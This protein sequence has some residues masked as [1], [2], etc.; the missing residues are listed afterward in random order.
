M[1]PMLPLNSHDLVETS[2]THLQRVSVKARSQV[3]ISSWSHLSNPGQSSRAPGVLN[4]GLQQLSRAQ[5]SQKKEEGGTLL[6]LDTAVAKAG[7]P[8]YSTLTQPIFSVH[9]PL[10]G[11][12][13]SELP[14]RLRSAGARWLLLAWLL[15]DWPTGCLQLAWTGRV[16]PQP[17]DCSVLPP[18]PASCPTSSLSLGA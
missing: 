1:S 17:A 5:A 6:F 10:P 16:R 7:S 15:A 2:R 9:T 18:P 13:S 8:N 11:L 12:C 14:P 3:T 4:A